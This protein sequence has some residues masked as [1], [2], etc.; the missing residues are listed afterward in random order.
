VTG[1]QRYLPW[2]ASGTVCFFFPQPKVPVDERRWI[3]EG[4]LR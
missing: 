1:L 2:E 3:Y 4:L